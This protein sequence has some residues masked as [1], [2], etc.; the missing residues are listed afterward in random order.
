MTAAQ[1]EV[2]SRLGRGSRVRWSTSAPKE[3]RS[4]L[5]RASSWTGPR[6]RWSTSAPK[7]REPSASMP[8]TINRPPRLGPARALANFFWGCFG[9]RPDASGKRSGPSSPKTGARARHGHLHA[10]RLRISL[11]RGFFFRRFV[12]RCRRRYFRHENGQSQPETT[13]PS[14][15]R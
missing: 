1:K 5:G 14:Q 6:V 10:Q 11:Q 15:S 8:N 7:E 4:R 2:N 3:G 13:A 9:H 12:R